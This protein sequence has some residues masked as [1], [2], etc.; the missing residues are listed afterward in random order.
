[1][2]TTEEHQAW[3]MLNDCLGQLR[4]TPSGHVAGIDMNAAL[5]IAEVRG[6]ETC[7]ISELL[8][9]AENGLIE[10]MNQKETD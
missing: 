1:M 4:F 9:A 2:I 6:F 5:K 3:D 7:V 10:A 8:S